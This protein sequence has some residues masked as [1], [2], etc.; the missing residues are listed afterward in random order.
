MGEV[1][2]V[3]GVLDPRP[4]KG[5]ATAHMNAIQRAKDNNWP[6]VLIMEDD[7]IFPGKQKTL[8]YI[9]ESFKEL[10]EDWDIILGGVY[11]LRKPQKVNNYWQKVGEFCALHW[12]IVNERVYDKILAFDKS[13]HIDHWMGKQGMNIYLPK[14]FFA[15]QEDG[16]SDNVKK[17][18]SYNSNKLANFEI[19][20]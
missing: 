16:Y 18:T 8:P 17:I 12:Y 10:P 3:N 1:Q 20:K 15:I 4:S 6:S 13:T 9:E 19:L 7:V 2:W 11:H 5:I 14:K